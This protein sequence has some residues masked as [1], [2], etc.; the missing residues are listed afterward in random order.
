MKQNVVG[1]FD[2]YVNDMDRASTFYRSVFKRELEDISDPTDTEVTMKS[3]PADMSGY[4]A[5]GA[6]V[7][8]KGATPGMGGTV[9]YFSVDDCANEESRIEGSGGSVVNP[10]MSIGEYGYVSLCIDTEGNLIGLSSMK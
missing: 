9:V 8:R 5:G 4:G 7:K 2:I 10:K 1:W 6:L 3:F